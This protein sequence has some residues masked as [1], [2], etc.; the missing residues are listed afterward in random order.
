MQAIAFAGG[1]V[2][3]D[4]PVHSTIQQGEEQLSAA[5][6]QIA[7]KVPAAQLLYET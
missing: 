7:A 1:G 6:S 4:V 5:F 3:I 2:F